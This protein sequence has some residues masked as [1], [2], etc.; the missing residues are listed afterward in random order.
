MKIGFF[1]MNLIISSRRFIAATLLVS[2]TL[3]WFFLLNMYFYSILASFTQDSFLLDFGQFL[4]YAFGVFSAIVGSLISRKINRRKMLWLWVA[5]GVI[6]TILLFA[7]PGTFFSLFFSIL[8][9]LSL[10][11]GLPSSMSFLAQST[12]VEKRG[13][14][15]GITMLGTFIMAF[16]AGALITFFGSGIGTAIILCAIVRSTSFIALV[17]DKCDWKEEKEHV[18]SFKPDYKELVFYLLCSLLLLVLRVI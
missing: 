5:F 15:A 11:L 8:L 9:G 16:I 6:S 1:S 3:A 4:F 17:L 14:I 7:I 2:G 13:R 12:V 18:W 10:G